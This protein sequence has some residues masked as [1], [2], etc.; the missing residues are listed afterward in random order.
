[1]NTLQ[2]IALARAR[3]WTILPC[4]RAEKAGTVIVGSEE[5]LL[6]R[7]TEFE[8]EDAMRGLAEREQI[9]RLLRRVSILVDEPDSGG[10]KLVATIEELISQPSVDAHEDYV[11]WRERVRRGLAELDAQAA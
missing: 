9:D 7:I 6:Q 10:D 1:M 5:D 2:E 11:V 3:G 8:R 4:V